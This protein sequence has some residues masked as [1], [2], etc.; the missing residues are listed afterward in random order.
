MVRATA[1]AVRVGGGFLL[2]RGPV[3]Q[4][5]R[6]PVLVDRLLRGAKVADVPIEMPREF[7]VGVNLDAARKIGV[8]IP[9]SIILRADVVVDNGIRTGR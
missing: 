9:P 1:S 3:A 6:I 8:V 2:A 7:S 4:P 5:E